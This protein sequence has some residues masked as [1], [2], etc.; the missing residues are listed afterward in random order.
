MTAREKY[1]FWMNCDV[2]DQKTKEELA[3]IAGDEKE[4]EERFYKDL[5]F[6]TGGL[7]GIL[8]AGTNRMNRY[9]VC[10]ATQGL[11]DFIKEEKGDE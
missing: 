8:G 6:G 5:E 10:K 9:T 3:A 11:A 7:R 1:E 4:I 2:F